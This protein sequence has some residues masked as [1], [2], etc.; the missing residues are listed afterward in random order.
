MENFK[1]AVLRE[2][3]KPLSVETFKAEE[4]GE[5]QVLVKMISAGLCGAQMNEINAV[6]GVDK[7]LPHFVLAKKQLLLFLY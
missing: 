3:F 5:G 1:A 6:K 2:H 7:Y 4:P